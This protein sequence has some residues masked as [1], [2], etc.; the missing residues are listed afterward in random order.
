MAVF[1]NFWTGSNFHSGVGLI[2]VLRS[3]SPTFPGGGVAGPFCRAPTEA[4]PFRA[5]HSDTL[6]GLHF[7]GGVAIPHW[8]LFLG[9]RRHAAHPSR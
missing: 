5:R 7:P 8:P 6:I 1:T 4:G 9:L 3:H 2:D